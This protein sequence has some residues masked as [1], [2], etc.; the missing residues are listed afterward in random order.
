VK[1]KLVYFMSEILKDAYTKYPIV[2]K[3][4]YAVLMTIRK[5]KHY[6]LARCIWVVSN[7]PLARILL[8]KDGR[9]RKRACLQNNIKT[10]TEQLKL[11]KTYPSI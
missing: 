10:K 11:N 2:M 6:F 4:L 7:R 1:Q 3:L 9:E 8:S 5:L